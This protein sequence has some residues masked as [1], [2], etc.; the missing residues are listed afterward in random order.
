MT[1]ERKGT[2][3]LSEREPN[4][5]ASNPY[6]VLGLDK[7]ADQAEIKRAYFALIRQHPPES[8]PE[9]FKL[10]RT[11]YEKLKTEGR[12]AETDLFLLQPP[13]AW[14]AAGRMPAID[15]AFYPSDVLL[16]LRRWGSDLGRTDFQDAFRE[17]EL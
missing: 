3:R 7:R 6:A 1:D 17:I 4:L 8:E 10:I 12:R 2:A 16:A 14:H 9:N 5:Q 11:A 15:P 13:P